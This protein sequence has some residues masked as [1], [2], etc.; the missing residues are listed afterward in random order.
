LETYDLKQAALIAKVHPNTLRKK[1]A[2]SQVPATKIGR[3]WIFPTH[4]FD[5]WIE[6]KCLSTVALDR[7]TGGVKSQSLASRLARR[8]ARLIEQKQKNSSIGSVND[9]GDSTN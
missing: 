7:P 3:S 5:S 8:R 6:N 2:L 1:A 4:L 9:S